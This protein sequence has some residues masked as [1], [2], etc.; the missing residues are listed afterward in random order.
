MAI[1]K[2]I[3]L[4]SGKLKELQAGDSLGGTTPD[5]A[6][7]LH[8][9]TSSESIPANSSAVVIRQYAIAS[10]TKLSLGLGA[11]FRIL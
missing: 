5:I 1:K 6:S 4:Y 3:V 2:P 11:R 7:A 8:T 9:P 10:G